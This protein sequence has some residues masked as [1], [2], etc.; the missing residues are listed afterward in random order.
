MNGM[1][2]DGAHLVATTR[3]TLKH[4]HTHMGAGQYRDLEIMLNFLR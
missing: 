1:H 2:L 3:Q 4:I